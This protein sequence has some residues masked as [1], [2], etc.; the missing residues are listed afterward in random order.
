MTMTKVTN[1]E[2]LSPAPTSRSDP[3]ISFDRCPSQGHPAGLAGDVHTYAL[4]V[5]VHAANPERR[6]GDRSAGA[7]DASFRIGVKTIE[8]HRANIMR[9]LH[10]RL[11]GD[12][13]RYAIR[14]KIVHP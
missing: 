3:L 14:N 9:K 12:L 13:V 2:D 4:V 11:V 7:D 5:A 10:L 6:T 8:A 1:H